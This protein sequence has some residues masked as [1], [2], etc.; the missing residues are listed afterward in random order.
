MNNLLVTSAGFNSINNYVSKDNIELFKKISNG[1]KVVIVANAAPPESGNY[2]ARENVKENFL[3]VGATK[4]DIV[5]LNKD[6]V[7]TILDYD[8]IYGLGGNVTHLI[9]LINNTNYKELLIEFLKKGVY[10][11][12]S[13]GSIILSRNVK[14]YYDIQKGTKPKYDVILDS[15]DGIGLIDINVFPHYQRLDKERQ[16]KIT[17]YEIDNNIKITRLNDGEII[18]YNY[19]GE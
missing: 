12:E 3:K 17:K 16:D 18:E 9:N 4:V 13:A 14:W 2:I 6:N 11:G 7:S 1:K 8:V 10:I 15:Y 19:Q 5:D